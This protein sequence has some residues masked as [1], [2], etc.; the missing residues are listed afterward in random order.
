MPDA[1]PR[2]YRFDGYHLDTRTRELRDGEGAVAALTA[3]AFDTLCFLIENRQRV[4][5]K[6]ALFAAVWPGRVVEDNNL[7]QAIATVRR[8]LGTDGSDHRFIVTVPGR[9]YR[10]VADVHE[11]DDAARAAA[12]SQTP[13][14]T[15]PPTP[16]ATMW[17]Q[18]VTVGALLFL[19]TLFAVAAWRVR[20]ASA[21]ATASMATAATLPTSSAPARQT[22]L[23]V[24]PFRSLSPGPRDAG[25]E[26]GL[27][28]TLITRLS[29]SPA[30]LVP[31]LTSAQRT[32]GGG[33]AREAGRQLGVAYVVEG[34]TQQVGGQVRVNARLVSVANGRVLWGETFDAHA[35][36]VFTLQDRIGD[37]VTSALALAP[38]TV[39]AGSRSPC[40]GSDAAAYRAYLSGQRELARPSALRTR[41]ALDGFRQAIDLDPTCA[42]AYAGMAD[43]YR[44]LAVVAD[45]DPEAIF[46]LAKAMADKALALDP[47]LAEAHVAQGWIKLWH[48]WDWPASEAEFRRAIELNASLASAYFGYANLLKHTGRDN[49]AM[50]PAKQALALDPLSPVIN[51]IGGWITSD[52]RQALDRSLELDPQYWL[53]LLL[54]GA[55]RI[56][57]GDVPAGLADLEQARKICGDCSHALTTLGM[58]QARAG[59]TD[60]ARA[61]L[62]EMEARDR[63]G[64]WPA[65][66]LATLHNA[67]GE[68]DAALDL[69]ERA[70]REHDVRMSFLALDLPSRWSNLAGEPRFR[71][72]MQAMKLPMQAGAAAVSPT[73]HMP[74]SA[75]TSEADRSSR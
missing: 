11:S 51:A 63:E 13:A 43:A 10:F 44:I 40:D 5:G 15:A 61:I 29:R 17:R 26:L 58:V 46:P 38:V 30:L 14:A 8:A 55:G 23:A 47:D 1:T 37:A 69:L 70:H 53:A 59:H 67:L 24:L 34:T 6:E 25:L 21:P 22:T 49:E 48:D 18:P 36:R 71:A 4:V 64:Y 65:S 41:R 75:N 54:R 42:R 7:T 50:A 39:P 56:G 35:D 16:L 32:T 3:K 19:L 57:A 68:T 73:M 72:L 66:S 60:A 12:P 45:A 74:A 27:A 20:E 52:P 33:D 62:H 28:E 9:G 2:Q 31:A